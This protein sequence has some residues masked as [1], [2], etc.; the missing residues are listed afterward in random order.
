MS[1]P[2]G[3]NTAA[4]VTVDYG[5]SVTAN[6]QYLARDGQHQLVKPYYLYLD[7]D[8][9]LAPTNTTAMIN[10]SGSAMLGVWALHRERCSPSGDLLSCVSIVL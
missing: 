8:S 5:D 4:M 7:Y 2:G 9:D 1:K 10:S 6:I 3:S